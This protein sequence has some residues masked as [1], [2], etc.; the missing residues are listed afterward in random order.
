MQTMNFQLMI[1]GPMVKRLIIANV[2]IWAVFQLVLD[3]IVLDKPYVTVWCGLIPQ[4][5]I[6]NF[7]LWQFFTYMFL[8]AMNPFHILFNMMG[9]WFLGSELEMRWGSKLFLGYYLFTGIGA[10]LIYVL[11][12]AI[13]GAVS[14]S[15]PASYATPVVGASGAVF[16]IL[17]AYGVL[18]GDRMLY[19][20]GA[21]P[22]KARYF[23]MIIAGV[24][25]IMLLTN[26]GGGVANLAHLGG[27]VAGAL[28]LVG[29]TRFQQ[30]KWRKGSAT[31]RNL[32]LVVNKDDSENGPKFW[33]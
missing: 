29:W 21:F 3:G 32:K 4:L 30:L 16:G 13:Y 20:F 10:G 17:L 14:G 5:V 7:F 9:L 19:F 6:E 23:V 22:I 24:E 12:L 18:F 26:I 31:R 11:T 25:V 33:N 28:F 27:L 2:A 15:V 1:P 8:H